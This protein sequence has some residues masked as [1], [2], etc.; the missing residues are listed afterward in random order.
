MEA[1][2]G[3]VP[4]HPEHDDWDVIVI[5]TGMGGSTV[6]FELARRGRRVL[7]LEKGRFLHGGPEASETTPSLPDAGA[8]SRLRAGRWP[9]PLQGSTGSGKIAVHAPRGGGSR[10]PAPLSGAQPAR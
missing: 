1:V 8:E 5:G 3:H 10:R 7:F 6:G 9:F 4:E 2:S